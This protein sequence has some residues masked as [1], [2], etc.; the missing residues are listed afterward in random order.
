ML[1][2]VYILTV[3][4]FLAFPVG[5]QEDTQPP[6]YQIFSMQQ[7]PTIE[8]GQFTVA[9][10]VYN[11][12]GPAD[13]EATVILTVATT[14]E[15]LGIET[16]GPIPALGT[17]T[18][19]FTFDASRFEP[20]SMVSLQASVGIGE[21]EPRE[22]P[23]I[24]NNTVRIGITIPENIAAAAGD[25]EDQADGESGSAITILGTKIE[26]DLQDPLHAGIVAAII[27]I[28]LVLLWV[29]T[30]IL[31]LLF[32]KSPSLGPW[33]PPY[34]I[35][36]MLDPDSTAGRRHLWQPHA[37][38]DALLLPCQEGTYHIRKLL[39][40]T[41]GKMLSGWQITAMRLSQYDMYGRVARTHTHAPGGLVKRLDRAAH[42]GNLDRERALKIARPIARS[43]VSKFDKRLSKKNAGLPVALDIRLRGT[44]GDARILFELFG[45]RR[46]EWELIDHWEP[47]V[48]VVH[49][50]IQE[51]FTYTM[52]GQNPGETYR[53]YRQRLEDEVAQIFADML[54]RERA[55]VTSPAPVAPI[56][57]PSVE[58]FVHH[59]TAPHPPAS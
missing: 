49:G 43:F 55:T 52:F 10:G 32:Q 24:S 53:E 50:A 56:Q 57:T 22:G 35:P 13:T 41:D 51:N 3:A 58:Q 27:V 44:H 31:R 8:N 6:D 42:K 25:G 11:I 36:P 21:V 28:L 39:L 19:E 14:G 37:Q 18:V 38:N 4:I 29:T 17:E 34:A 5:A 45:C 26:I 40:G 1:R 9:F 54:L 15:Q 23:T 16:I 7:Q 20:G 2:F 33:Q 46:G 59:D 47:E 48:I 12:G 30:I